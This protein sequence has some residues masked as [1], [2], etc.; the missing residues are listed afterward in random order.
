MSVTELLNQIYV[1]SVMILRLKLRYIQVQC[2]VI[3]I[4]Q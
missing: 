4:S 1:S 2:T 3:R